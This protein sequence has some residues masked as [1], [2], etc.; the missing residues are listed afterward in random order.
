VLDV[1]VELPA[2]REGERPAR[3]RYT[4]DAI[5][6]RARLVQMAIDARRQHLCV[7]NIRPR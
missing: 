1:E 3:R 6:Q 7:L 5:R 4:E 2:T